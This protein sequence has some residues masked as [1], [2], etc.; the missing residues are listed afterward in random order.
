[1]AIGKGS[2]IIRR[3]WG[4]ATVV[5]GA[6]EMG[7]VGGGGEKGVV[8]DKPATNPGRALSN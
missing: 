3:G 5:R 4:E 2:G 6:K 7:C 8:S 1:M